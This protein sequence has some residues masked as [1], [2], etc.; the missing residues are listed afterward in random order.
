MAQQPGNKTAATTLAVRVNLNNP[1]HHLWNNNG[2]WYVH[3]THCPTPV[4]AERVRK[5]LRTRD[6]ITARRRR[7]ELF[8]QF[9]WQGDLV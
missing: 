2:T 5:S 6:I 8:R 4:T 7:N 9:D 3:Y 1:D